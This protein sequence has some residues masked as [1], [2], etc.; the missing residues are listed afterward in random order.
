[1]GNFGRVE[2]GGVPIKEVI[3]GSIC[4]TSIVGRKVGTEVGSSVMGGL[5]VASDSAGAVV[6]DVNRIR[7][8][9]KL[10]QSRG[11]FEAIRT[12]IVG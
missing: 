12:P 10:R 6:Q 1:M 7:R 8:A 4:D 9:L 2:V 3:V 11:D 5:A